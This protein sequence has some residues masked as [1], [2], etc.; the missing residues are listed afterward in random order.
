MI[1]NRGLKPAKWKV[2][3]HYQNGVLGAKQV[4]HRQCRIAKDLQLKLS[5]DEVQKIILTRLSY[6]D[7]E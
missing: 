3:I 2:E 4:E 5:N 6:E 1:D 7:Y